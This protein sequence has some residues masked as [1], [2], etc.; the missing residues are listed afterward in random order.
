MPFEA[1]H[2]FLTGRGALA[3]ERREYAPDGSPL[4]IELGHG[5]V[6]RVPITPRGQLAILG[7]SIA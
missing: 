4:P 1:A 5:N 6:G 7:G 3:I 2:V